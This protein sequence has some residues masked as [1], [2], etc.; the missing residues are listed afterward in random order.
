MLGEDGMVFDD[1]VT[2]RLA[3]DHYLMT[4]TTG[5]AAR[6]LAWME[7]CLQCEWPEIPVSLTSVTT[8]W[9]TV[10]VSG[11]NARALLTALVEDIDLDGEAFPHMAV[12]SG[13]VAGMPA[14]VFRVSYTGELSYEVNVPASAG[15]ALWQALLEAGQRH[16]GCPIGTEALHILRAEKG[17][18]AVGQDTD[19]SV[20]P[21]DLGMGWAV[22]KSKD[23][24]GKRSLTRADTARPG[25]KQLVGLL[26]DDPS[27]VLPE[28]AHI[29][30]EMK[31]APPMRML[32]HVTSSYMSPSLTR[33][34]ALALLA[35]GRARHGERVTLAVKG[36]AVGAVVTDP[37]FF[38]P[39]GT[40]AHA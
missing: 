5:N 18:I 38:D 9:A 1:G 8:Q 33:S 34:I 40:R 35:D 25:R 39:E 36:R 20:T 28:G 13:H 6:V 21:D 15:L 27:F 10:A 26:S 12:R 11:P 24:L 31:A 2:A 3:N 16:G 22:S 32:G 30:A 23:F 29:V 7:D 17:Y 14:R 4:T 19:G 37:V